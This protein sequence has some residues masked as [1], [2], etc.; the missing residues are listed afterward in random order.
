MAYSSSLRRS[1]PIMRLP[2][3]TVSAS[4]VLHDGERAEVVIFVPAGEDVDD[5]LVAREP[6]LPV[7]RDGTIVLVA[8][9][10]IAALGVPH[11]PAIPREDDL[12]G[13]TQ[14]AVVRLRSGVTIAGELRWTAPVG[15]QRTADFLNNDEPYVKVY[16]GDTTYF[17]TK[18]H[19]VL[20]EEL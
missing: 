19:I 8:R 18:D 4:L 15:S 3:D 9:A 14:A 6:F 10:A 5:V 13:E 11:L 7:V 17:V 2:V 1:Q 16:G 20:V 12:P